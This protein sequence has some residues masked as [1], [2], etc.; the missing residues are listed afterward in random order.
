MV[1]H[2][3][4]DLVSSG[5]A[6]KGLIDHLDDEKIMAMTI[7]IVSA[8]FPIKTPANNA[9]FVSA[10][11]SVDISMESLSRIVSFACE[12]VQSALKPILESG[13][14]KKLRLDV[15]PQAGMSFSNRQ[16]APSG[17]LVRAAAKLATRLIYRLW[18]GNLKGTYSLDGGFSTIKDEMLK[19]VD[20]MLEVAETCL[21]TA[22][23]SGTL[24]VEKT[25]LLCAILKLAY[26]LGCG[27][28]EAHV[29][30]ND[31]VG[32]GGCQYRGVHER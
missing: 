3:S 15:G 12:S 7:P 29:A 31:A 6:T 14:D 32:F 25:D 22:W 1:S 2:I 20:I 18:E 8:A 21:S 10:Q 4:V 27:K 13:P 26:C 9:L 30:R 11:L 23:E 28:C 19:V 16:R 24:H 5:M 17:D